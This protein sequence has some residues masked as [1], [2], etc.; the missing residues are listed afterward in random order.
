MSLVEKKSY[1]FWK[2]YSKTNIVQYKLDM[3]WVA[4]KINLIKTFYLFSKGTTCFFLESLVIYIVE[5]NR[6]SMVSLSNLYIF[7]WL[8]G[9]DENILVHCLC[10]R[11]CTVKHH[12]HII[13]SSIGPSPST[14]S[15]SLSLRVTLILEIFHHPKKPR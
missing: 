10:A 12:H 2:K 15:L 3:V 4:S 5:E 8:N 1:I 6:G 11:F 14:I 13:K 7:L 9:P